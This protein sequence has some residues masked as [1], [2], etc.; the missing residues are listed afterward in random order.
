MKLT[1][2]ELEELK[3]LAYDLQKVW[4]ENEAGLRS[5]TNVVGIRSTQVLALLAKQVID[6]RNHLAFSEKIWVVNNRDRPTKDGVYTTINSSGDTVTNM[7]DKGN[8]QI[9]D[10]NP[11]VKWLREDSRKTAEQFYRD[12][13]G[14]PSVSSISGNMVIDS[15]RL[16]ALMDAYADQKYGR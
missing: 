2:E 9:L 14:L 4:L 8:W 13:I 16:F 12:D 10:G 6:K 15:V 5:I 11:V 7:F 1:K 3:L